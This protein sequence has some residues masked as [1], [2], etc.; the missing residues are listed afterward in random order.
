MKKGDKKVRVRKGGVTTE[1][2]V[3]VMQGHEP[4]NGAAS[5]SQKDKEMD[6]SLEPP[7]R[8]QP[9]QSILDLTSRTVR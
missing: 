1:A 6:D 3:R 4:Q 2:E 8:T 7:E 9:C 5:R